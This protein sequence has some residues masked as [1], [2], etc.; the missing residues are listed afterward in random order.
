MTYIVNV[1]YTRSG[2]ARNRRFATLSD[3][4]VFV[5]RVFNRTGIVLSIV[6]GA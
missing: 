5:S 1:G 3:A 4:I 6:A 2:R